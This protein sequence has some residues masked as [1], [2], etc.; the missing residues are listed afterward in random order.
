MIQ[1]QGIVVREEREF[2]ESEFFVVERSQLVQIDS[3]V[4]EFVG[5]KFYFYLDN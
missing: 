5:I 1:K 4:K 2:G 3:V